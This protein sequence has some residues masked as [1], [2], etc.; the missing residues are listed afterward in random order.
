MLHS[1]KSIHARCAQHFRHMY[2]R[3][4]FLS[5][6]VHIRT[7][8]DFPGIHN[9]FFTH[10]RT[11]HIRTQKDFPGI[12]NDFLLWICRQLLEPGKCVTKGHPS[13]D[14]GIQWPRK[15]NESNGPKHVLKTESAASQ[16]I[17][18]RLVWT[19]NNLQKSSIRCDLS[20]HWT[21]KYSDTGR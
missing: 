16:N 8:K 17:S 11:Q 21:S 5:T 1:T 10:I 4:V 19:S 2:S 18:N 15:K 12:H 9:D 20:S 3:E 7:Q 13:C 6:N 14:T